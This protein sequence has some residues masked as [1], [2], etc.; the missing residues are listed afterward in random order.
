MLIDEGAKELRR[1]LVESVEEVEED[2]VGLFLSAGLDSTSLGLAANDA[3]KRVVALTF[4]IKGIPSTDAK[5]AAETA[6]RFGWEFVPFVVVPENLEADLPVLRDVHGCVSKTNFECSWPFLR[7]MRSRF[8]FPKSILSGVAADGHFGLSKR[9]MIHSRYPK[10]VFDDFRREYFGR[11]NPAGY[12]NLRSIV[13]TYG[14]RVVAPYLD[15]LVFRLLIRFGWDELN[16]PRQKEITRRAFEKE[17]ANVRTRRHE[18]LQLVAGVDRIF[19]SLLGSSLNYRGR[20]RTL[21]V[22]RDFVSGRKHP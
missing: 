17:L 18:N 13:E 5:F 20:R 14:S 7:M 11:E 6:R 12:R 4:S 19:E 2:T 3:G 10:E 1:L 15:V 16:S 22:L 9:A 21:D 8:P